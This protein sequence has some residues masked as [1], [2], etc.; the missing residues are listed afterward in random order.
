MNMSSLLAEFKNARDV[1]CV[2]GKSKTLPL[3]LSPVF[4]FLH[5]NNLIRLNKLK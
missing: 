5:Q 4:F 3:P 1:V 2:E